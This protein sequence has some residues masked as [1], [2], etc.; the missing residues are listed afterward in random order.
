MKMWISHGPNECSCARRKPK[1][2]LCRILIVQANNNS[3]KGC[4]LISEH[5]L[6]RLELVTQISLADRPNETTR[7]ERSQNKVTAS[8][9]TCMS[10]HLALIIMSISFHSTDESFF[11][12]FEFR[13]VLLIDV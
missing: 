4:N 13:K 2:H 11:L 9:L 3:T 10:K 12:F 7:F 6:S 8:T 5:D 1:I